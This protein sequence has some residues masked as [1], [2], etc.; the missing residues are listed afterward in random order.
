[1]TVLLSLTL[2]VA[3]YFGTSDAFNADIA[4]PASCLWPT[5]YAFSSDTP[6]L[7]WT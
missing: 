1:M 3:P 2:T 4:V 6:S 5:Y 7:K